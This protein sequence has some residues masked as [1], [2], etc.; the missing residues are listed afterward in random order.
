MVQLVGY[1][2]KNKDTSDRDDA[3]RVSVAS[4]NNT[5]GYLAPRWYRGAS[6]FARRR[7]APRWYRGTGKRG[8]HHV[9]VR[10]VVGCLVVWRCGGRA[11]TRRRGAR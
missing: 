8:A 9:V 3:S 6:T 2:N 10:R 1:K 4:L 11:Q 7:R 5:P